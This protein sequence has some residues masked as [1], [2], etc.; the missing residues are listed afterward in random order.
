[1]LPCLGEKF[2][3]GPFLF[4]HDCAPMHEVALK[5]GWMSLAWNNLTGPSQRPDHNPIKHIWDELE[6]GCPSC[7]TLVSDLRN[8][9]LDE[10]AKIP[11]KKHSYGNNLL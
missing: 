8:A 10:W 9:L 1:M 6:L 11:T 4:Q 2:G 7:P 3:E 5:H